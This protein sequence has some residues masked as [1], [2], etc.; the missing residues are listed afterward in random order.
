MYKK[1]KRRFEK[2][3]SDGFYFVFSF[4]IPGRHELC[5]TKPIAFPS[6]PFYLCPCNQHKEI[7]F[8]YHCFLIC[9]KVMIVIVY[10]SIVIAIY[11]YNNCSI[12]SQW[13]YYGVFP[14]IKWANICNVLEQIL[15]LSKHLIN[16]S[17]H[18]YH[19][20][21]WISWDNFQ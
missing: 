16:V 14:K 17:W 4:L 6:Q 3:R 18:H 9:R 15:A 13:Y 1:E 8:L 10:H 5:T 2:E 20:C 21:Y 11:Y 7:N 12:L 19:S